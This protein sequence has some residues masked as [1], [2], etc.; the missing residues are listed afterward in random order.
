MHSRVHIFLFRLRLAEESEDS[1]LCCAAGKGV[2]P[3]HS[4]LITAALWYD[5]EYGPSFQSY[6]LV[7]K[8]NPLL[9]EVL[10]PDANTRCSQECSARLGLAKRQ[11]PCAASCP[12]LI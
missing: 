2:V 9:C 8:H 10:A 12:S 7:Y 1:R 4:H 3:V 6:R 5:V 11:G